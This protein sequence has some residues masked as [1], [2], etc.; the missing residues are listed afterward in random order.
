MFSLND[1]T[2]PAEL[3]F[4]EGKSAVTWIDVV[5]YVVCHFFRLLTRLLRFL[6]R[7][8]ML[9]LGLNLFGLTLFMILLNS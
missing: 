2:L 7:V 8:I 1:V 4:L 9:C 3:M 6:R 5:I